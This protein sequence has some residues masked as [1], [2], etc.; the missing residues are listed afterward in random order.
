MPSRTQFFL[1]IL[2]LV[3]AGSFSIYQRHSVM[4]IPLM[5][6][7]Q[8]DIWKIEA[9]VKFSGRG[10]PVTAI[11]T[12][13]QDENFE[14]INEF[15]ASSGY[16]VHVI[17]DVN[18][19][20][21]VWSKRKV[22]G[23]QTLYY[24]ASYKHSL[25]ANRDAAPQPA[26]EVE[27]WDELYQNAAQLLLDEA[28]Q[29]SGN[30][31]FLVREFYRLLN[32]EQQNAALILS[33]FSRAEAMVH[34]MMMADVPS[35]LIK[36]LILE[37]GRRHQQLVSLVKV[38]L[39]DKWQLMDANDSVLLFD[40]PVL[41]WQENRP[42]LLDLE[43]GSNS[44]ASFS[45]SHSSHSALQ[46]ATAAT[47]EGKAFDFSLYHLPI[48]EQNLF[49]GILLLPIGTLVVVFLRVIIGLKCSGTFMP[50]LIATSFIQT[51]LINGLIGFLAIVA[52]GLL[53]RSYLSHLNLLLV[54]RISA[55]VILVIGIIVMFT[56]V[57]FRLGLTEALTITYFPMIILAWT[58]ERMSILWEEEGAKEVM[59][60]GGGSLIVATIAYLL[61]DSELIRHWAFNF[62]GIHLIVMALVLKMGQYTGYRLLELRRFKPMADL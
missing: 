46:E 6:G 53:I 3:L 14:L 48:A 39:N 40:K 50:V 19:A 56:V 22:T 34:L 36:G 45:I 8:I 32:G 5:P 31:E 17:R 61:M 7:E 26:I 27:P 24:Q 30:Q 35:R 41:V 57:A 15:T 12:L 10:K 59:I 49:K 23:Q 62:L 11:L 38:Y 2:A 37:D 58:I 51:T 42:S 20:Q 47:Q 9:Q 44:R 4:G 18:G 25:V 16:G 13:P 21:V 28:Y 60:Q 43:G 29:K 54:S 52:A 1:L 33:K 55:V